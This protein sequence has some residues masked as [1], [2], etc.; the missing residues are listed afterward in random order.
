MPEDTVAFLNR[1]A[2]QEEQQEQEEQE[3]ADEISQID[4]LDDLE[5]V[6]SISF[7]LSLDGMWNM[8]M[9]YVDNIEPILAEMLHNLGTGNLKEQIYT[10]FF[11]QS[12]E[13]PDVT[14]KVL[15]L[16]QELQDKQDAEK[17]VVEEEPIVSPLEALKG[18]TQ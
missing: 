17:K 4:N 6:A 16:I 7:I 5:P 18:M 11:N 8:Y 13:T 14:N 1:L 12:I 9:E 3:T 10:S 2:V 15:Q